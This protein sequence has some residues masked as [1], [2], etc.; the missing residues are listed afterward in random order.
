LFASHALATSGALC[1]VNVWARWIEAE[2][3]SCFELGD[4]FVEDPV[5]GFQAFAAP[6]PPFG[7][8]PDV[9]PI[10]AFDAERSVLNEPKAIGSAGASLAAEQGSRPAVPELRVRQADQLPPFA[11][12]DDRMRRVERHH[13]HRAYARDFDALELVEK[14]AHIGVCSAFGHGAEATRRP[15]QAQSG[16]RP[17][18]CCAGL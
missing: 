15:C 1:R 18:R 5:F 14:P 9:Q 10:A 7:A 3:H 16:R 17:A 6:E 2:R 13:A 11:K 12:L 8:M 4:Q